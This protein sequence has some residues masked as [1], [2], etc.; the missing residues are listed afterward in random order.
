MKIDRVTITGADDKTNPIDLKTLSDTFPFVEWGIL[1][2]KSKEGSQRYPSQDWIESLL[3]I[4]G[5]DLSAHFC[6]WWV[7]E[8][9]E[10]QNF[11]LITSLNSRFKRIQLNYNFKNSRNWD[12]APLV[13][14]AFSHP[15]RSFILQL[16]KSNLYTITELTSKEIPDNIHF[17]YDAS[18]G[19]GSKIKSIEIPMQNHYTGYAGGIGSDNIQE[20]CS[21][22]SE[23]EN[24]DTVW[25]D[26]ES[27]AR[28]DNEFD[29]PT[30]ENILNSSKNFI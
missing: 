2:S 4:D 24:Y 28:I 11:D 15:E 6:G 27:G 8:V 20:I 25:V 10:N 17:L 9:L 16:N 21:L 12:L 26:L 5:I 1:Y 30:V 13:E 14:Y 3:E 7:K 18:G 23:N 19:N 29:I 22:I